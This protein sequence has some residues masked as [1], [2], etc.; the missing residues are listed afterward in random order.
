MKLLLDTN[1]LI[2]WLQGRL[3][4]KT[5]KL[6]E[7]E[8]GKRYVSSAVLWEIT[9]KQQLA[10]A[11]ITPEIIIGVAEQQFGAAWLPIRHQHVL[12]LSKLPL[13]HKD[14]FDRIMLAQ[15]QYEHMTVL[16]TDSAF[17]LYKP[18]PVIR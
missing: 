17:E 13:H 2:R 14:P 9:L 18:I 15:A 11:G 5:R 4:A 6:L 3:T 16:T 12:C 1:I 7:M 8:S 10:N